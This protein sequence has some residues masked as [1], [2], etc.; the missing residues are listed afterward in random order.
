MSAILPLAKQCAF[1][2]PSVE[3][4]TGEHVMTWPKVVS[5]LELYSSHLVSYSFSLKIDFEELQP[6]FF[7]LYDKKLHTFQFCLDLPS[8]VV[9]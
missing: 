3:T 8:S 7:V 2:E 9:E 1:E 4:I 5:T 6:D